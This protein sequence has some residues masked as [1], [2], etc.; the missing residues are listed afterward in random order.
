MGRRLRSCHTRHYRWSRRPTPALL[1]WNASGIPKGQVPLAGA[2]GRR[3]HIL[4]AR[5]FENAPLGTPISR[6]ARTATPADPYP[7]RKRRTPRLTWGR[8]SCLPGTRRNAV[9]G[10]SNRLVVLTIAECLDTAPRAPPAN[11]YFS[12]E[13]Y[14]TQ[15]QINVASA[16]QNA[17]Y[18]QFI[19][20]S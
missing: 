16:G 10:R 9:K 14:V 8:Y 7:T 3:P 15:A 12:H 13:R 17:L 20:T 18:S 2:W 6:L 19:N 1:R 11:P 5:P 4:Q